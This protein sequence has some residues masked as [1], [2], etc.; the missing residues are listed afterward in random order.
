MMVGREAAEGLA[1]DD[2]PAPEGY[3]AAVAALFAND[4]DGTPAATS[5]VAEVIDWPREVRE[6]SPTGSTR[7]YWDYLRRNRKIPEGEIVRACDVFDLRCAPY[8]RHTCRILFPI[9]D[10]QGNMIAFYGRAITPARMRYKAEPPGPQS[11]WGLFGLPQAKRGGR[12]L[13]INEGPFDALNLNIYAPRDCHAVSVQT[14]SITPQQ[15]VLINRLA[16]RYDEVVVMLD[17]QAEEQALAMT[18]Q[19]ILPTRMVMVPEHRKDPGEMN[20]REAALAWNC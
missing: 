6:I 19:L 14:T 9:H 2:A 17:Q 16:E 4:S 18:G 11:K 10:W 12:R 13:I 15:K 5:R 20:D 7:P 1:D 3:D 8:G